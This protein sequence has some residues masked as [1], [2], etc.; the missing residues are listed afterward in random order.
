MPVAAFQERVK[1]G[2][3][4]YMAAVLGLGASIKTD[5]RTL[6]GDQF[7]KGLY[8]TALQPGEAIF[9]VER[10]GFGFSSGG[11]GCRAGFD[12]GVNVIGGRRR[13]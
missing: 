8:E 10:S 1:F 4:F 6:D 9:A 12:V 5:R 13:R 7:F 2:P 11:G 3:Y